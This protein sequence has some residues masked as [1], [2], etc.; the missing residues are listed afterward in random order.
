MHADLYWRCAVAV[1][2]MPRPSLEA[3]ARHHADLRPHLAPDTAPEAQ[4]H[5]TLVRCVLPRF[6]MVCSTHEELEAAAKRKKDV[7][8]LKAQ[9]EAERAKDREEQEGGVYV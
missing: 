8:A 6:A 5:A 1:L 2:L 3:L 7:E 4:R 9:R